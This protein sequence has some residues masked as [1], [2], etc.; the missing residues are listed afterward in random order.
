[1]LTA[2]QLVS[3]DDE[4][5]DTGPKGVD[6]DRYLTEDPCD[7]PT[8]GSDNFLI[9]AFIADLKR[10]DRTIIKAPLM[11]GATFTLNEFSPPSNVLE[12][13][14]SLTLM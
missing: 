7:F 5:S 13:S 14:Q 4:E 9:S 11:T 8:S 12:Y 1:M 3:N 10:E 6:S 2:F